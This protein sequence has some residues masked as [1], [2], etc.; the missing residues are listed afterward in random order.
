[1]YKEMIN[2]KWRQVSRGLCFSAFFVFFFYQVQ[3]RATGFLF[4]TTFSWVM[5]MHNSLL[6]DV[7]FLI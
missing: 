1:V 7:D 3:V 6:V 4:S 5:P 2:S